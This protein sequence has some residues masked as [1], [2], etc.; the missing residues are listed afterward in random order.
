MRRLLDLVKSRLRLLIRGG[1]EED[2][3]PDPRYGRS[4][5][6]TACSNCGEGSLVYDEERG[7]SVCSVCGAA[8]ER[9]GGGGGE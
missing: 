7:T 8:D 2:P 5:S 3:G 1:P 4:V 6:Y 9:R